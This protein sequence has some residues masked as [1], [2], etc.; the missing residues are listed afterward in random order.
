MGIQSK[1][2]SQDSIW[3]YFQNELPESFSGS[4][5]RLRFLAKKVKPKGKVLNIG[6]G[7]GTFEDIA[8]S[9]G[10]DVYSLDPS[11]RT[12]NGLRQKYGVNEKAQ[13]G[14]SQEIPFTDNFFDAVVISEVIEHLPEEVLWKTLEE[15]YRVLIPNGLLVGTVPARE[16]L[17]EQT[18]VCPHCGSN[19]HRWGHL[20]NFDTNS[21]R[22]LLSMHFKIEELYERPFVTW[23]NLNWKGF[24]LSFIKVL[25][26]FT[27]I[28][29]S[30]ENIVFIAR[31]S[32]A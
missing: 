15:I 12:I 18:V 16:N 13:V 28:H 22:V 5:A 8:I 2:K 32:C 31:K 25:L 6:V 23:S 14:Y 24:I 4:I 19:F 1:T 26:Y 17:I 10:L 7:G 21:M 29:G 3:E 30:N 27:G 11:E 20:Q 9:L